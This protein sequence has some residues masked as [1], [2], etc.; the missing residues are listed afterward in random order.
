MQ[1]FRLRLEARNW[2]KYLRNEKML[3]MDFD[4]FYFC[5]IAGVTAVR[6]KTVPQDKTAELV[7]YFPDRYKERGRLLVGLFLI[8]EMKRLG[9]S[10]SERSDVRSVIANLVKPDSQNFLSAEGVREFNQYAHGGYDQLTEWF[11][12]RPRSLE[13][14]LRGFKQKMDQHLTHKEFENGN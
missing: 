4:A 11:D 8:S 14:F 2:F 9:V 3:G 7:A 5:F 10:M 12:E 6:K 13:T 1:P